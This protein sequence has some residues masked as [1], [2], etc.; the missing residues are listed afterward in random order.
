MKRR[1]ALLHTTTETWGLA[2]VSAAAM[3]ALLEGMLVVARLAHAS[4][5]FTANSL[6]D[7]FDETPATAWATE[8]EG[9]NS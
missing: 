2:F 5:T 6:D 3:V 4:A 7:F 9:A 1:A 8:I